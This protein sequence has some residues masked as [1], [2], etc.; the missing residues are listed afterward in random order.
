MKGG[1]FMYIKLLDNKSLRIIILSLLLIIVLIRSIDAQLSGQYTIGEMGDFPD[2][3]KACDSLRAVGV[4]SPVVFDIKSGIYE[5]NFTVGYINGASEENTITFQSES[6][7]TADVIVKYEATDLED[8]YIVKIDNSSHLIFQNIT[9]QAVGAQ[10]GG[11]VHF[12]NYSE[13]IQFRGNHFL[14]I[15]NTNNRAELSAILVKDMNLRNLVIENNH[16]EGASHGILINPGWNKSNV[17][18]IIRNN[19]FQNIGYVGIYFIKSSNPYIANNTIESGTYGIYVSGST[20]PSI[21]NNRIIGRYFGLYINNCD[22]SIDNYS[23]IVNNYINT[24]DNGHYN[25]SIQNSNYINVFY[26]TTILKAN[27]RSNYNLKIA[28]GCSFVNVIN[29][30]L[31]NEMGG[32]VIWV[33]DNE[34]IELC[35]YNNY[36][37]PASVFANWEGLCFDLHELRAAS[38]QNI[39]STA[40]HPHFLSDGSY[41]PQSAWLDNTGL[42][43]SVNKDIEGNLRNPETPDPGC[44]EFVSPPHASPPIHGIKTIGIGGDYSSLNEAFSD[45]FLRGISDSVHLQLI[46]GIH[47]EQCLIKPIPGASADNPIIIESQSSDSADVAIQ[48]FAPD[49]LHNYVFNLFG[50]SHLKFRNLTIKALN[51]SFATL[52]RFTG[53]N[54]SLEFMD[55]NFIGVPRDGASSEQILFYSS[56]LYFK[57]MRILNNQFNY[58]TYVICFNNSDA[59]Y[60]PE[61]LLLNNNYVKASGYNFLLAS[62]LHGLEAKNNRV[63][64]NGIGIRASKI[65]RYLKIEGN[66]F[67]LNKLGGLQLISATL[68]PENPGLIFNNIMFSNEEMLSTDM[69][70][71]NQCENIDFCHNTIKASTESYGRAILYLVNGS[72]LKIKNNILVNHGDQRCY[73]VTN[74]AAVSESDYNNIFTYGTNLATWDGTGCASLS[75]LQ[76]ESGLD[77]HSVTINPNFVSS[78]NLHLRDVYL[79]GA[80]IG[81]DYI[82]KDIDGEFRHPKKPDIGADEYFLGDQNPPNLTSPIPDQ[83]F[84]EDAGSVLITNNLN[85]VF[86]DDEWDYLRFSAFSST[87]KITPLINDSALSLVIEDN[88]NGENF[89]IKVQATDLARQSALDSFLVTITSEP[90][91]PIAVN[92]NFTTLVNRDVDIYPLRNDFDPENDPIHLISGTDPPNGEITMLNDSTFHYSPD[93]DFWGRDSFL[94]VIED[95]TGLR[96]SA[97]VFLQTVN[98]FSIQDTSMTKIS[99]GGPLWGDIDNDDDLDLLLFGA[100][101]NQN[102]HSNII[103]LNES[104]HFQNWRYLPG[105][106]LSPDNP[107]GAS[108]GDANNDGNL[109]LL[110]SGKISS[111]PNNIETR[112]AINNG[113]GFFTLYQNDIFDSWATSINW[114]DYDND[115]DQDV[116]ICGNQSSDLYDPLTKLYRND[117]KGESNTWQFVDV[118]ENQFP[119]LS[120]GSSDW[121]DF[122]RDGDQDLILCGTIDGSNFIMDVYKNEGGNFSPLELFEFGICQGTVVWGDYNNDGYQDIL[123]SGKSEGGLFS[124]VMGIYQN[125]GNGSFNPISLPNPAVAGHAW[126]VDYNNDGFLDVAICG[127]DSTFQERF[128]LF[129]NL[130]MNFVNSNL[131]LPGLSGG[132]AWGDYDKDG[133]IDMCITGMDTSGH[134]RFYLMKNNVQEINLAPET[135]KLAAITFNYESIG[136]RWEPPNDDHTPSSGLNYNIWVGTRFDSGN[137]VSSNSNPENGFRKLVAQGNVGSDTCYSIDGVVPG[138]LYY[139]SVQAIDG[140]YSGSKFMRKHAVAPLSDYFMEKRS[141]LPPSTAKLA[142]ADYDKD[143]KMDLLLAGQVNQDSYVNFIYKRLTYDYTLINDDI[144]SFQDNSARWKDFDGDYDLDV[145][146]TGFDLY[147][148]DYYVSKIFCYENNTYLPKSI[149]PD[150]VFQGDADWFDFDNDGDQDVI[151]IGKD[152]LSP[153]TALYE[154]RD[155]AFHLVDEGFS[156]FANGSIDWGDFDNDGDNDILL[157]GETNAAPLY[158]ASKIYRN[159]QGSFIELEANLAPVKFGKGLF[160]DYDMDG[161]L[162][163]LLCGRTFDGE[164]WEA[165]TKIYKNQSG[166]FNP[167]SDLIIGL[168]SGSIKWVDLDNDGDLDIIGNGLTGRFNNRKPVTIYYFYQAGNYHYVNTYLGDLYGGDLTIG[169]ID[170]DGA[171][172]IIQTGYDSLYYP[173]T[174]LFINMTN[175]ENEEPTPPTNLSADAT[176]SSYI[177][178]WEPAND[179]HTP[180]LGLTYNLRIGTGSGKSDLFPCNSDTSGYHFVPA[181][182]NIGHNN[183]WEIKNLPAEGTLYWTV[184]AIDNS[185]SGSPFADEQKIILTGSSEEYL[186]LPTNFS[187]SQ[188]YPNPFNPQTTIKFALPTPGRIIL[189]VYNVIGQEIE[190]LIEKNYQPGYHQIKW[191]A[192]SLASGVYFYRIEIINEREILYSATRKTLL[193]K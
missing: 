136:L 45:L 163:I 192:Q 68:P 41:V 100:I 14:G 7:D 130:E 74:G 50:A 123:Y 149:T 6:G 103:Y 148:T 5:E 29:N 108:W 25:I 3:Q 76:A 23:Q 122:D 58:G 73:H 152:P 20:Y 89:L 55:N 9:F 51:P 154:N 4:S 10:Y 27:L 180:S 101:D 121:T 67:E 142:S 92:D 147:G 157:T 79:D 88:F 62:G 54:D 1:I 161:D 32:Y 93:E 90:D 38:S 171:I 52:F 182:G 153:L 181:T 104:G 167:T 158:C 105:A 86:S 114:I 164:K 39:H 13:N 131:Y 91:P 59:K 191:N 186:N 53:Q 44:I 66:I 128:L 173:N 56:E 190:T 85:A 150:G 187:L 162:D 113:N 84:P 178:S 116:F 133:K 125:N 111:N 168:E 87:P 117:G 159:Y 97:S 174:K 77:S 31:V 43:I 33:E 96:D 172:D 189:K 78:N 17:N 48:F 83:V 15:E 36:Y 70:T 176:D 115:G 2:I 110:I 46:T 60:N 129:D 175:N 112:L 16:F 42:S 169:D 132:M 94:Y 145:L 99:N 69:I 22:G 8:N 109:D 40:A 107:S 146:V 184:Q 19:L 118:T 82:H 141:S 28:S 144:Q 72:N 12:E 124:P 170:A 177:F 64:T 165:I 81:I 34:S 188:N 193:I 61:L 24:G 26:N 106:A 63:S 18:P 80:G 75:E 155:S 98:I 127:Y 35:D 137:I 11:I 119:N 139:I 183:S 160:G 140:A 37:N 57:E 185:F 102:N 21:L 138:K 179:D 30:N 126:W 156:P 47:N 135:P 49:R 95:E 120:F 71:M 143:S 134:R 65:D 166:D 151:I